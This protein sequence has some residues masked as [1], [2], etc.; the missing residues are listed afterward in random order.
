MRVTCHYPSDLNM[1]SNELSNQHIEIALK[2]IAELICSK[3][4]K[5]E[6]VN[7]LKN[8]HSNRKENSTFRIKYTLP[9]SKISIA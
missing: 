3:E 7:L 5:Y 1:L 2:Y 8:F 9:S 6:L 4:Q